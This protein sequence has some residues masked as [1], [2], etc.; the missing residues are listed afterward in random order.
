MTGEPRTA[1]AEAAPGSSF[2]I[3]HSSFI[4]AFALGA[5]TVLGFA[6]FALFPVPVVTVAIL[7]RMWTRAVAPRR[8]ALLGFAFGFGFF[9]VGVSWIYVSL[10]DFGAMPAPLAA[11]ATLLFCAFL[12]LFPALTGAL[13]A[14]VPASTRV[15]LL[16]I[17]PAAWTLIEWTRGW[18][19]TG[20]PWLALGYSQ[21][22]ASPLAGYT[23]VL[24]VYGVTLVTVATAGLMVVLWNRYKENDECGTMNAG[25]KPR[26]LRSVRFVIH[27]SSFIILVVWLGGWALLQ[28]EWTQPTGKPVTV[29][30]VQGNVPQDMKWRP[31]RTRATL[32]QYRQLVHSS[33]G[34]LIVLPETALPLFLEQV[35]R[36]YLD[37]LAHHARGNGGDVLIGVPERLADGRY[38][39]SVVSVGS[40]DTQTYRK[41]HLVPFGEFIPLRPLLAGIVAVLSIPLQDFAAGPAEPRPLEVAGQRIAVNICYEDAFGEEIIRQLPHATLL[42]NV[43]NVAWFGRSLAP[44]QHLQISQARALETGRYMLR[45]TNTGMTAIISPR[46]AVERHAPAFTRAVVTHIVSGFAGAT[47]YVRWGNYAVLALLAGLLVAAFAIGRTD[48]TLQRAPSG[49]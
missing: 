12:A 29:S 40:A 34:Q 39:N 2:F 4:I 19:F 11:L 23:P 8:A 46:G 9:L 41:S 17:A 42:A 43:S 10:H 35:P 36:D 24:G 28:V 44:Q 5:L 27:H 7:L 38:Y 6:P 25:E 31:E 33:P 30:L 47:P 15:R 14:A 32:E 22:P 16:L 45:A 49:R 37:D 21:V 48:V 1:G 20:F 18:I 3:L 13:I 26:P